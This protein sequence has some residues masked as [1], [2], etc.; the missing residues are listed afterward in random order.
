MKKINEY[1]KNKKNWYII[2]FAAIALLNWLF[3][4]LHTINEKKSILIVDRENPELQAI[5]KT[6]NI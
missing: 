1:Q 6:F 4:L 2:G 3:Y 5:N